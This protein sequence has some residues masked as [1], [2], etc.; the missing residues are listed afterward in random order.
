[1]PRSRVTLQGCLELSKGNV[2][3]V[4]GRQEK[5]LVRR[6]MKAMSTAIVA[7][8]P[9]SVARTSTRRRTVRPTSGDTKRAITVRA[10]TTGSAVFKSWQGFCWERGAFETRQL[11]AKAVAGAIALLTVSMLIFEIYR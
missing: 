3:V 5:A 9:A 2:V 10:P 11:V 8:I 7:T 1:M 6:S 4:H